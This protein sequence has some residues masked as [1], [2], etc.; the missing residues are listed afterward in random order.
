LTKL[1]SGQKVHYVAVVRHVREIT[2]VGRADLAF[3]RDQLESEQLTPYNDAGYAQVAVSVTDLRWMGIHS[4]ELTISVSVEPPPG[5]REAAYLTCAFNT[6]KLLAM[7][8]RSL[9]HTPYVPAEI[10]ME[11]EL[12]VSF[13][14]S[15]GEVTVFEARMADVSGSGAVDAA[16]DGPLY[17]PTPK[18][19]SPSLFYARLEGPQETF[20]FRSEDVLTMRPWAEHPALETL[21]AS[22][23]VAVEWHIRHNA[24]HKKSRTY[25]R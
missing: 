17:L 21:I 19:S 2:V 15:G 18:D 14:L 25:P 13:R 4:N 24:T 22:D 9:F 23:F 16:W 10:M 11:P 20:R 1:P 6:S 3:W 8:E 5:V 12:P 7:A